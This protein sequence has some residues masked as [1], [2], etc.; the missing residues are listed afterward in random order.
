MADTKRDQ[1]EAWAHQWPA[2]SRLAA[3]RS[4]ADSHGYPLSHGTVRPSDGR[5]GAWHT[6]A[7]CG[8]DSLRPVR[9]QVVC[10][11]SSICDT[12]AHR[13]GNA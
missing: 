9:N 2:V 5:L 4:L 8:L 13:D 7:P 10:V 6:L 3:W 11:V 1:T 12:C